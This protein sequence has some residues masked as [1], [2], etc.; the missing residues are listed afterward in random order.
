MSD[1]VRFLPATK[2][3]FATRAKN[4]AWF[5]DIRLQSAQ[6]LLSR[7]YGFSGLHEMQSGMTET[8]RPGPYDGDLRGLLGGGTG[9]CDH[10]A[11]QRRAERTLLEVCKECEFAGVASL[12]PWMFAVREIGLFENTATH[13]RLFARERF[14]VT[15]LRGVEPKGSTPGDYAALKLVELPQG[16]EAHLAF[17]PLGKAIFDA[18][19]DSSE[20]AEHR[21]SEVRNEHVDLV[22]RLADEHEVNP[23][24][25]AFLF[26]QSIGAGVGA[27]KLVFNKLPKGH[28]DFQHH[29]EG[30]AGIIGLFEI[31]FAGH[32][33]KAPTCKLLSSRFENGS[34]SWYW[35]AMLYYGG[36][37]AHY[38]GRK[39][40]AAQWLAQNMFIETESGDCFGARY[41]F[42][43]EGTAEQKKFV[44]KMI[45]KAERGL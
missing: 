27:S 13:R 31:L 15:V 43:Q 24:A 32:G 3:D 25:Q 21:P 28:P 33:S 5:L 34:D 18:H 8:S 29:F 44:R 19:R 37:A 4:L 41:Y 38:A 12:P 26:L 23:W 7:I 16:P 11:V 14:K 30:A 1:N 42:L 40:L 22:C 39:D 45:R 20:W 17:T 2:K 10:G 9:S 35:S 6:S 36:L